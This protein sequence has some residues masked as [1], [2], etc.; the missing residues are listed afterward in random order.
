ML[1]SANVQLLVRMDAS[2][3]ALARSGAASHDTDRL[4]S[5]SLPSSPLKTKKSP[6]K[7]DYVT[8]S[9]PSLLPLYHTRS[10]YHQH[11]RPCTPPLFTGIR[12]PRRSSPHACYLSISVSFVH[13]HPILSFPPSTGRLRPPLIP[14]CTALLL[15]CLRL[16]TVPASS[17]LTDLRFL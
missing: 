9:S 7:P 5:F 12:P 3:S 1:Q 8:S 2:R 16:S 15:L 17:I 11:H 10:Q 4:P 13:C 6:P 14:S